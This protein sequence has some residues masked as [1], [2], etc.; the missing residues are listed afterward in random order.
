MSEEYL[1]RLL[2]DFAVLVGWFSLIPMA[3]ARHS[4]SR[5]KS[6]PMASDRSSGRY[7]WRFW[8]QDFRYWDNLAFAM[9]SLSLLCFLLHPL[10]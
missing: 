9:A 8:E 2:L 7:S 6:L 1:T 10:V 5:M 4:R 3:V